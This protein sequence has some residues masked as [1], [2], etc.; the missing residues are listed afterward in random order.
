MSYQPGWHFLQVPGPSNVPHRILR[1][2]DMPTM[3]H[4]S[5]EFAE[6]T[7][8]LISGL[9]RVF[10]TAIGEVVIF[11]ASGSGAWEAAIRNTLTAGDKVVM[12]ET[13]QFAAL[14]RRLAQNL[15]LDVE[16][17]ESDW[18]HPVD[19]SAI[20]DRLRRDRAQAV[21][22]V[23]VVH[24]ETSTGVL[25]DIPAVRQALDRAGHSAMLMVD[26]V[27]S[28]GS[29]DYRHDEWGVDVAVSGS[30]KGLMLPPGLAF[31]AISPKALAASQSRGGSAGYFSWS[32]QLESNRSGFFPQTPATNTL[33]GLRESLKMIEEQ[34]LP[35]VFARHVRH[36]E[37]ARRA[38]RAWGLELQCIDPAAY[39]PTSHGHARA[40]RLRCRRVAR[41]DPR[42][43]QYVAGHGPRQSEGQGVSARPPWTTS[44]T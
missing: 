15:G 32:E 42:A 34:G 17:I 44:T 19:A 28:L 40:R 22:A 41:D 29:A 10:Q 37:A 23:M 36:G 38:A 3:D 8:R 18:R 30:Q 25:S 33:F 1:A 20:E 21:K 6:L 9:K 2:I 39:S 13:G 35:N 24:N 27:S 26:A 31:N 11:S 16:Y 4:R 43:L 7:L 14:W 12:F 5:P